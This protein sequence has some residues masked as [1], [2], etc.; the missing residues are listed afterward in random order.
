M[1]HKI[2]YEASTIQMLNRTASEKWITALIRKRQSMAIWSM[3][4]QRRKSSM[5]KAL[6][7]NMKN[8]WKRPIR[9][10]QIKPRS[11]HTSAASVERFSRLST[12][13]QFISK[14]LRIP[15]PG[16]LC[17]RFVAKVFVFRAR[18]VDTR[19]STHPTNLINVRS[20]AKPSTGLQHSRHIS[21]LTAMWRSSLVRSA[22]KDFIKKAT[23]EI[24]CSFIPEKSLTSVLCARKRSTSSPT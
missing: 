12:P 22:G 13:W 11:K 2:R 18:S 10:N 14:C 24:T 16:H 17:A 8:H 1:A 19:L 23:Y 7:E 5:L 15:A 9:T 3:H 20:V 4:T 21:E 6:N